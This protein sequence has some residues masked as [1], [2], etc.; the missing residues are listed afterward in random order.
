MLRYVLDA[1]SSIVCPP[2]LNISQL[3]SETVRPWMNFDAGELQS[4]VERQAV[5]AA[6]VSAIALIRWHLGRTQK[7]IFC[8]K[9]LS[10]V[11]QLAITS[12]VFPRARF[13]ML[14]RNCLDLVMS[15]LDAS[16]WGFSAFGFLPYV[17]SNVHN[18][19]NGLVQY[20]CDKTERAL[21]FERTAAAGRCYRLYYEMLVKEPEDSVR[22]L[23]RFLQV[24]WEEE[25][26]SRA[27]EA[28]H[29]E[30]HGD[31]EVGFT[32]TIDGGSLGAGS[33]VPIGLIP[34]GLRLRMNALLT[35]LGYPAVDDRWNESP[36]PLLVPRGA[37]PGGSSGVGQLME[38]VVR[39]R[40]LGLSRTLAPS[41]RI[42]LRIV[43]ESSPTSESWVIDLQRGEIFQG[44]AATTLEVVM[45]QDVLEDIASGRWSV[46][47][48][49][50]SGRVRI[51]RASASGS[52]GGIKRVVELLK[53][54][55]GPPANEMLDLNIA[56]PG[57]AP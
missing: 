9:S 53:M 36:S 38:V 7:T 31:Y 5:A 45:T 1:H 51:T 43:V 42:S 46:G 44:A 18:F 2:E 16:R 47:E 37:D 33:A 49:L 4:D 24:P 3:L 29:D 30:G 22:G 32:E 26:L 25:L 13:V 12:R 57:A 28:E 48:S 56:A 8:D 50:G 17:E 40:V 41:R 52:E 11:D 15:G 35:Q 34:P 14:Y 23:L 27:F 10:T 20:W 21:D 19:V 6:R 39:D 55:V 54:L